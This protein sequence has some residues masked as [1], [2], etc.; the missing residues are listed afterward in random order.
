MYYTNNL[1]D[2][3]GKPRA[4]AL[5]GGWG[6]PLCGCWRGPQSCEGPAHSLPASFLPARLLAPHGGQHGP[7]Y[8]SVRPCS[9]WPCHQIKSQRPFRGCEPSHSLPLP[10]GSLGPHPLL[11]PHARSAPLPLCCLLNLPGLCSCGSLALGHRDCP[12]LRRSFTRLSPSRRG[13]LTAV[14]AA[15]CSPPLP[16]PFPGCLRPSRLL[17]HKDRRPR[18][19]KDQHLFFTV[20][21][22]GGPRSRREGAVSAETPLPGLRVCAFSPRP[23][24]A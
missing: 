16:T 6:Q 3:T 20:L 7:L 24:T 17:E 13:S 12:F 14:R 9:G 5:H 4:C 21:K 19:F 18:G 22:P 15:A 2:W 10:R 23:R 1:D 11:P 8:M